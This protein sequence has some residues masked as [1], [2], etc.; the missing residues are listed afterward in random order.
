MTMSNLQKCMHR[1]NVPPLLPSLRHSPVPVAS[2]DRTSSVSRTERSAPSNTEPQDAS[3]PDSTAPSVPNL[4]APSPSEEFW[5]I[6]NHKGRRADAKNNTESATRNE[7]CYEFVMDGDATWDGS[8]TSEEEVVTDESSQS[9]D[10]ED[11]QDH[12]IHKEGPSH[13]GV[14]MLAVP[15]VCLKLENQLNKITRAHA[16]N[17]PDPAEILSPLSQR[18]KLDYEISDAPKTVD[19]QPIGILWRPH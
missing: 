15:S 6:F 12:N 17:H 8:Q 3:T 2:S 4:T 18:L 16:D 13:G 10:V 14:P 9:S 5:D 11:D 7:G 19:A 1:R